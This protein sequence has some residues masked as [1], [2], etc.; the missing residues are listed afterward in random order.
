MNLRNPNP[1][2]RL[3]E[4]I[5]GQIVTLN[6]GPTHPATHGVF[7]NILK[8]DG[9]RI[10]SAQPTIG[11]IHRAFEKI[12]EHRPYNQITPLT[13]RLN[14]C[15]SPINNMGWHMTVEKLLGVQLPKRVEYMRIIIM[16]LSRI[17]DHLVCNSVIGVDT[18]ALTGFTYMFQEREKIYELF[19]EVCGARLTTNIGR[20]G[21]FERDFSPKFMEK[22]RHFLNDFPKRFEEF[23]NL[24]ERN[25]IFID[26]TV[27]TGPISA[28]RALAYSFAGPNLRAAGVDYD[29]RVM[30]P[31]SSYQDFDFIIP[32]GTNGDTYDRFMVRQEEIRQSLKLIKNAFENLPSG[33]HHADVPEFYLPPKDEVYTRSMEALIY[34]FK[35]VM[36]ETKIPEGEVYHSV[37]GGNGEL[38]FYLI[39]D[40]GR[41]PYRLHFRRPCFIYYQ[42]Y[43]EMVQG[44]MLSDAI[45]TMSSMNVIAG[46]LDA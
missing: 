34:H 14:Y 36:G 40:G 18:G 29:V 12:A 15:S 5:D 33:K 41:S 22:L 16:E 32:I 43:P 46:E 10:L 9:E 45:L 31:Y 3:D 30:N 44:G 13:D 1:A 8:M 23:A 11:Y 35:I 19:E 4:T 17:A 28:E 24:L 6:L 20:I 38:G 25:R 21:G 7:Q 27:N 39:S 42:A 2:T 26:R 37:E